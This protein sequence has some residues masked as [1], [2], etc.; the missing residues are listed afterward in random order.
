MKKDIL[1]AISLGI[2]ILALVI[3]IT[4]LVIRL[5]L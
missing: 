3:S 1:F 4:G 2:S 5:C